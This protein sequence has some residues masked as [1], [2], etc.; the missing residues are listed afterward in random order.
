MASIDTF[1]PEKRT[2][3]QLLSNTS[4]PIRVPDFQR[5]F[6]WTGQ[7][8]SEFWSDLVSFGGAEYASKLTGKEYF[9][10]AAVLVNNGSYHLLL[11]GQQR[12]ATTTILLAVLRDKMAEYS[13][14]AAQQIQDLYIAFENHLTGEKIFKIQLNVFDRHFFRDYIQAFPRAGS[15]APTK[16][17]HQLISSAYSY[18]ESQIKEGWDNAGGGKKGF[19]WAGNTT[20]VLCEHMALVTVVSNNEKSAASIFATLNDRGIGLSTVDLIRSFVLQRAH[21]TQHEE[22]LKYWDSTLEACGTGIGAETLIRLSWVSQRG[23]IK[24]RALYKEVSDL[25]DSGVAP[26]DYSRRLRDD[27]VFYRRLREGDAD[28]DDQ[29]DDW[30]AV[31]ILRANAGYALLLAAHNKLTVDSQKT[32]A[33]AVVGLAIRHNVVCDLDRAKFESALYSAAKKVSA[34]EGLDSALAELRSIS[35]SEERFRESF[36]TLKFSQSEHGIA[37]Y[38]LGAIESTMSKTEEVIVAGPAKVHVEHIYPQTPVPEK[39]WADHAVYVNRAGNLTL[40]D[41]GL[42]I[43]I[44]NAD[45]E[46]KKEQAYATSQLKITQALLNF[47]GEWSPDCVVQRQ[48]VLL[49]AAESIWPA[50]LV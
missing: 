7:Q 27:A 35:P 29:Q 23:D 46:T 34:G 32:I 17:S 37:R 20:V 5:D 12:L 16:K 47:A 10:G 31:R 41:K 39:R 45:F 22:I 18:F 15:P 1:L 13:D 40:L 48:T 19:E 11:D 50:A 49:E 4:P 44:K 21:Q 14:K 9:L 43:G 26:I 3:G 25:L 42:N 2:L 36:A 28:D 33:K 30:L 38:F 24:T 8:V 6:S